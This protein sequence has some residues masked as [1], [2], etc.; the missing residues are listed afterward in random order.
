MYS[1]GDKKDTKKGVSFTPNTITYTAKGTEADKIRKSKM[2]IIVHQ[3]YHGDN[4]KTMAADPHPD[5]HNF[6]HH[7]DVWHKSANHDTKQKH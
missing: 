5:L 4:I 1:E 7:D 2:G 3:Q 6:A